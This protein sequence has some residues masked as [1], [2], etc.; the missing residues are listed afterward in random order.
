MVVSL[1]LIII[2]ETRSHEQN[3]ASYN[4]II[5]TLPDNELDSIH[6]IYSLQAVRLVLHPNNNHSQFCVPLLPTL[7]GQ[8]CMHISVSHSK[9]Y[10]NVANDKFLKRKCM[11]NSQ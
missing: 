5:V 9:L 11:Q 8:K 4:G 3:S 1:D 7:A 6:P 2:N 10:R